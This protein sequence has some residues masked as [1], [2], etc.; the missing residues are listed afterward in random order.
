MKIIHRVSFASSVPL[1][2]ELAKIG[3][4]VRDS[5]FVSF[6]IDEAD[7]GWSLLKSW[8]ERHGAV[9]I[10]LTTFS[11]EE[12]TNARWLEL[13][14]D[15]HQGYPQPDEDAF[16][17]RQATYDL[18]GW[19][20]RC[21]VGK[22]QKAAFQMKAEPQ[23]GRNEIL[24]MNWVFDELF[25]KPEAWERLLKPLGVDCRPVISVHG[26]KL[27]TVVQLVLE[28]E[29]EIDST[30][31]LFE[32]CAKCRRIK[33]LPVA[34]GAFPALV[35]T[36]TSVLAKTREEFGSGAQANKRIIV[37]QE[38]ARRFARERI[39]GISFRPVGER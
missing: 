28:V 7:T 37:A 35:A 34:R 14:A 30:G 33:Y 18:T 10:I 25:A 1:Q 21:G 26:A 13:I 12:V 23:W 15:R 11:A 6:E 22:K 2:R 31:I 36:P 3:I 4:S 17:Y 39:R 19:C 9:D 38:L 5:G 16:G 24:Q 8:I 20:E 27:S 29:V 32:R